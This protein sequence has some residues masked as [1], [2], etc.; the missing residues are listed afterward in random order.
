M[1]QRCCR[2]T[3][4]L[5]GTNLCVHFSDSLPLPRTKETLTGVSSGAPGEQWEGMCWF[6]RVCVWK[7]QLSTNAL[8]Y[9]WIISEPVGI[10]WVICNK[11]SR[12]SE[13]RV[14]TMR[15]ILNTKNKFL[16]NSLSLHLLALE[17]RSR[18]T[19]LRAAREEAAADDVWQGAGQ[20]LLAPPPTQ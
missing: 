4:E 6:L 17:I 18:Y 2:T 13:P 8:N 11:Q 7:R 3:K 10:M 15:W 14:T 5:S 12:T 9:Q 19:F 16:A 1:K 20:T